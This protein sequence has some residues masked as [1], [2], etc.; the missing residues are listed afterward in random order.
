MLLVKNSD[1]FWI[2]DKKWKRWADRQLSYKETLILWL[3][4]TA[5][6]VVELSQ[7]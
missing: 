7:L 1:P 2:L 4:K 3:S 6:S 5:Y